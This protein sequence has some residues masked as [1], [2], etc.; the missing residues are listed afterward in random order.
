MFFL[1]F[2]HLLARPRQSLLTLMGIALGCAAFVAFAGLMNG[3]QG[4][5]IDQLVNNDAHIRISARDER[6]EE[7]SLDDAFFP[8]AEHVFWLSPPSG[9]R[10]SA[11]IEN[12]EGWFRRMSEDPRVLAF[13]PQLKTQVLLQRGD[14]SVAVQMIGMKPES[15]L[16]VTNIQNYMRDGDFAKIGNMGNHIVLGSGIVN[17]LGTRV[18]ENIMV[19]VGSGQPEPFKVVGIFHLGVDAFDD[20][21]AF[22]SLSDVQRLKGSASSISDI[23]VRL[24]NVENA[25]SVAGDWSVAAWDRVRSWDQISANVLSVFKIQ[26]F[27]RSFM[28]IS[29]LVVAAFGV[30][31]ILNIL[32]NQKRRDIAILRSMGFDEGDI[33][34]LFLTQGLTLGFSGGVVGLFFGYLLCLYLATLEVGGGVEKMVISYDPWIYITGFS[35]SLLASSISSVLPSR[36]AGKLNPIEVIRSG[37]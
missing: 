23:A 36:A 25:R 30:Y 17:K 1:A 31:N 32:V 15:Q 14:T 16:R 12:P 29:I 27:S 34:S 18:S 13:S 37:G 22:A 21:L 26:D 9:R 8:G 10:V 7:H 33:M 24:V 19:S 4:F 35:L 3:F 2:K 20:A 6:I 5:I 28:T 11:S